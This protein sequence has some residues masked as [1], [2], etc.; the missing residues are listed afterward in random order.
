MLG[1]K[2]ALLTLTRALP[3]AA[4]TAVTSGSIDLGLTAKGE[5]ATDS[6]FEL[7]A[8]A[9]TT[10]MA[11]DTR[12]MTYALLL[13]ANSDM[14]SPTIFDASFIVQTGAGGVGAATVTRRFRLPRS[15]NISG[16]INPASKRYLGFKVTSGASITD[17]SA[18]SATLDPVF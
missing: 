11:P 4:S 15:P 18:V 13:S 3:A 12:T 2:D 1:L 16:G 9:L 17:S 7:V 5:L 14:S 8:P 6:E 10:T